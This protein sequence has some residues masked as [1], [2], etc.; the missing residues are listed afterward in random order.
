MF[1]RL[2][3]FI[4]K[5][6]L[7]LTVSTN[8][9]DNSF[10][11][12]SEKYRILVPNN[13]P[14]SPILVNRLNILP[15]NLDVLIFIQIVTIYQWWTVVKPSYRGTCYTGSGINKERR[16][17]RSSAYQCMD[18]WMAAVASGEA[19]THKYTACHLDSG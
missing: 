16:L 11:H 13:I 3:L 14:T 15:Q 19:A 4:R 12:F 2:K 6:I 5:E 10:S 1:S 7:L 18:V 9:T 8:E 17:K